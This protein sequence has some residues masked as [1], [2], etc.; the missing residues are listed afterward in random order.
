[1]LCLYENRLR[2]VRLKA[3]DAK[4]DPKRRPLQKQRL[5]R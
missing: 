4:A 2:P 1:M 3:A 5:P